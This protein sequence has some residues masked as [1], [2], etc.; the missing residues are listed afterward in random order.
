MNC[1]AL[2][3]VRLPTDDMKTKYGEIGSD[4]RVKGSTSW[5]TFGS[6]E[7]NDI[8]I[9]LEHVDLFNRLDGLDIEF[10]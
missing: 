6:S 2:L 4:S 5:F 9:F 7:V 1:R 3:A 8:A 10:L